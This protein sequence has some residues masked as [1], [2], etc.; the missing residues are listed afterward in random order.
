MSLSETFPLFPFSLW[1][2][3]VK[4]PNWQGEK[5]RM[6]NTEV[7]TTEISRLVEA[8]TEKRA[9]YTAVTSEGGAILGVAIKGESGYYPTGWHYPSYDIAQQQA[10]LMNARFGLTKQEAWEIV[11]SSMAKH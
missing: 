2:E 8:M 4:R 1:S 9:A 10:E 6:M 5:D 3:W 7:S 11:A